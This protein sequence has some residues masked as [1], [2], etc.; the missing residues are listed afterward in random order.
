MTESYDGVTASR[1]VYEYSVTLIRLRLP[2][3]RM[4]V[5]SNTAA[6]RSDALIG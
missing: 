1:D 4:L 6:A 3:P 5:Y 2:S